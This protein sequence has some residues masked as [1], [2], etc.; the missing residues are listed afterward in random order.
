MGNRESERGPPHWEYF[1]TNIFSSCWLM[2]I[3]KAKRLL[4]RFTSCLHL[5]RQRTPY[6]TQADNVHHSPL[7]PQYAT[8][9]DM[10]TTLSSLL[11]PPIRHLAASPS[12][13]L[14]QSNSQKNHRH[15]S[16][17]HLQSF[18]IML[19]TILS[20]YLI[21]EQKPPNCTRHCLFRLPATNC[22]RLSSIHT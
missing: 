22:Q 2:V 7:L 21:L 15:S 20:G 9:P 13:I 1:L 19:A 6:C 3:M 17:S 18:E 16:C 4:V 10:D 12:A 11:L 14:S 5:C 8:L